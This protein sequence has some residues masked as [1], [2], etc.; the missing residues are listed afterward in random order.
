M[1]VFDRFP[2][3][4][5]H[6]LNLDW[7]MQ[8]I[9]RYD[10]IISSFQEW[11]IESEADYQDL[12][13]RVNAVDSEM[14]GFQR[15][16]ENRFNALQNDLQ[17]Q[18]NTLSVQLQ[19][20]I[21]LEVTALQNTITNLIVDTRNE[22][23][24]MEQEIQRAIIDL[25]GQLD[26]YVLTTQAWVNN[27]LDQ[28][29]HDFPTIYDLP[30]QNP[31]TGTT[32]SINVALADLYDRIRAEGALTAFEYDQLGLTAADYDNYGISAL[33]YDLYAKILLH[34]PDLRW[35]M[36]DPFTGTWNLI[37]KVVS[38]LA[39]LHRNA[40]TALQYDNKLL[41]AATYDGLALTAYAYDWNGAGLIP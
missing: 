10:E 29:L 35:S 36:L 31:V 5:F 21:R 27:R 13:R 6:E 25:N 7:I 34:Y 37:S 33:E 41:D 9:A 24:R 23:A 4:N 28:F 1:G 39:D 32:T 8:E 17:N 19:N 14:A 2:F 26:G 38:K 11:Q 22:L 18:I 20:E 3:T 30:V 12:L 16:M 40:L 15:N